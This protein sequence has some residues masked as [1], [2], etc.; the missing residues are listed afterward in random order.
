M[1]DLLWIFSINIFVSAF[2]QFRFTDNG[3][4]VAVGTISML[5]F[6]GG[7]I[8]LIH[9]LRSYQHIPYEEK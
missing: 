8:F 7:I 6:L 5:A 4:D 2:L 9:K 3:G 1:H